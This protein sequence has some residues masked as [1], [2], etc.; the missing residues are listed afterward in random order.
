MLSVLSTTKVITISCNHRIW[1]MIQC[2]MFYIIALIYRSI[3][4]SRSCSFTFR[5]LDCLSVHQSI[6]N[7]MLNYYYQIYANNGLRVTLQRYRLNV[8][9]CV[10]PL[11]LIWLNCFRWLWYTFRHCTYSS[12]RQLKRWAETIT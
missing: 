5:H 3:L 2:N 7:G 11:E 1:K 12:V 9:R 4:S 6:S 10:K 8:L